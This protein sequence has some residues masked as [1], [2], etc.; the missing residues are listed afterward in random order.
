MTEGHEGAVGIPGHP[1]LP[2]LLGPA[3]L[4]GDGL[5]HDPA[6]GHRLEEV[7]GVRHPHHPL[8]PVPDGEGGP[9]GAGLL[10]DRGVEARRGRWSP[11]GD[12]WGRRRP[13]R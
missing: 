3:L 13:S 7:G 8:A 5:D 4:E 2:E 12:G 10:D 11:V 1:D 9:V 6:F